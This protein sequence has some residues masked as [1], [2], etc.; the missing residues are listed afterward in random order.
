MA[1]SGTSAVP[2][3]RLARIL[4]DSSSARVVEVYEKDGDGKV[5]RK[6]MD[7]RD[8]ESHTREPKEVVAMDEE[9]ESEVRH[10][11]KIY[12]GSMLYLVVM[13]TI[14]VLILVLQVIF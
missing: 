6:A 4:R 14:A 5:C 1:L 2:P 10:S 9:F 7:V 3:R 11:L 12:K 13:V 8:V